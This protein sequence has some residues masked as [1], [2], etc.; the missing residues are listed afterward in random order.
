MLAIGD[1]LVRETVTEWFPAYPAHVDDPGVGR[2]RG[3]G[4]DHVFLI[5]LV[6]TGAFYFYFG[7]TRT[8]M[9]MRAVVDDAAVDGHDGGEPAAWCGGGR[10]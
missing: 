3:L 2:E 4:S 6:S 8:G 5:S 7:V 1:I 10:G 9:A